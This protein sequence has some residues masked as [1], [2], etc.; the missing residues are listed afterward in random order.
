MRLDRDE[1]RA[2]FGSARVA[3]FA[4]VSADGRPHLVP[5]TFAVVDD[6]IVFAVDHK[7]KRTTNL[8]R[9]RN[10]ADNPAVCFLVDH[11]AE[12]WDHLWWVRADGTAEVLDMTAGNASTAKALDALSA[13]YQQYRA[14]PPA[15]PMVR[16][17]VTHW[18]GWSA[19]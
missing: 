4:T 1:A 6:Q 13:K 12:D 16:T 10:V 2:R 15:G 11:Y 19:T 3:R 9:L 8:R 14:H 7:P 17:T 18:S 5:V